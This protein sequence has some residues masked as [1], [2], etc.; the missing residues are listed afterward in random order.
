MSRV[1]AICSCSILGICS[2][3][4]ERKKTTVGCPSLEWKVALAGLHCALYL[5][6]PHTDVVLC[7]L[8]CTVFRTPLTVVTH[9]VLYSLL[10]TVFRTPPTVVTHL[11]LY[12]LPC[13][14]F[15]TA[16]TGVTHLVLYSLLCTVFRTAPT[17]VT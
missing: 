1:N 4:C 7:S 9:L 5:E 14:V 17:G 2:E 16:L 8:L 6:L 10:C 11:V 15:R 13:T 3:F 12:S